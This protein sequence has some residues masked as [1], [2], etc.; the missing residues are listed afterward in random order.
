ML[1]LIILIML[2]LISIIYLMI[3]LYLKKKKIYAI[4]MSVILMLF[5][6]YSYFTYDG[7]VRLG[8]ATTT[9]NIVS[10]Y[11]TEIKEYSIASDNNRYFY[12]TK[13]IKVRSGSMGLLECKNYLLIICT[14]Y[15][16]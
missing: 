9:G 15:G 1:L 5:F 12:S 16:Y 4:I 8:I 3:K 7:A 11:T 14:Y 6:V 13:D 10:A 2:V